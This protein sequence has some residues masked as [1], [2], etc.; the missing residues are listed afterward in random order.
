MCASQ[1]RD[2]RV[3]ETAV[4]GY[5]HDVFGQGVCVCH[6]VIYTALSFP[7]SLSLAAILAFVILKDG[8]KDCDEAVFDQLKA[9]VKTSIGAFA[10]PQQFLVS[11]H[12]HLV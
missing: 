8:V 7:L 6:E 5:P 11:Q 10:T 9:L 12:R 4:V 3:A 2:P 1:N